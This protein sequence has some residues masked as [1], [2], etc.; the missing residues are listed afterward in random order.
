M[1]STLNIQI[2]QLHQTLGKM[3]L[4]LGSINECIVW[5]DEEGIIQWCNTSFDNLIGKSHIEIL[6]ANIFK[7]FPLFKNGKAITQDEHP[8][9]VTKNEKKTSLYQYIKN[10]NM[11]E[12]ELYSNVFQLHS[13]NPSIIT[14]IR[15]VTDL[16]LAM[17][18]LEKS[19]K[20]AEELAK[21][22]NL[23]NR[24]K[25]DFLAN[26]S[27]ELRT[28]MNAIIGFSELIESE[29][30][31]PITI[32]QKEFLGDVLTSA[33][34]LLQLINNI[35]DISKVEA[36]KMEFRPEKINL[37]NICMEILNILSTLI[38]QKRIKV[39]VNISPELK[40]IIIDPV[41]LKQILYNYL[42]NAIKFVEE[43]GEVEI[44]AKPV[45]TD[46]FQ[47]DVK[48]NGIGIAKQDLN[49]IFI[50]FQQLDAGRSKKHQGIGLGLAVTRQIVEALGGQVGVHSVL[51]HGSTFYAILPRL[52]KLNEF[53]L[54]TTPTINAASHQATILVVE[55]DSKDQIYI[56]N[57]LEK[58]GL[59]VVIASNGS[60]AVELCNQHQ[61]SAIT[62]DLL[63][64]DMSGR[65]VYQKV[66]V[67][68]KNKDTPIIITTAL[69]GKISKGTFNVKE[70]LVKPIES[71][72]LL[73]VLKNLGIK[74]E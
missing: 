14:V 21:K 72:I 20:T 7:V 44:T 59:Q 65:D 31:G 56:K 41:R 11:V 64:P 39:T 43:H 42:S 12:L 1:N 71:N 37:N 66:H 70:F 54:P 3:E 22:A 57:I 45:G 6:G 27:H 62:L 10:G 29:N 23:A 47:L 58:A 19:K 9:A 30:A 26:M 74:I 53:F 35:L 55:D 61:F 50:E 2:E 15:D 8:I 18:D 49:K 38:A 16:Y 73:D 52:A 33:H 25:S 63:L 24:F 34:H 4:A 13:G 46:Q 68:S 67:S 60:Q 69:P 40:E 32:Q 17:F 28:P 36:G 5:S 51:D 48:D